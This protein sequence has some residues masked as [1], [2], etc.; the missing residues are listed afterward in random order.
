MRISTEFVLNGS[1]D[2]ML[3]SIYATNEKFTESAM[4][5][6]TPPNPTDLSRVKA[7]GGKILVYHGV[8]D[9]IFSVNDT[10]A[11]YMNVQNANDGDASDFA[12]LFRIPGMG[13]C[14]RGPATDQFDAISVLVK[15]VEQGQAPDRIISRVRGAGNPGGQNED[16]PANWSPD[17]TRP[18]CPYPA[19]AVYKGSGDIEDAGSFV[20]K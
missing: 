9:S 13:H 16:L 3:D 14:R 4:E 20:C 11:W 1:I 7:R 8:S 19:V 18:L 10:E 6:M 12:R 17:R 2:A 15:W 5:F